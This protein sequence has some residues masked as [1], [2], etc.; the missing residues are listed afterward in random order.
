MT[1]Q[2]FILPHAK[3]N[4]LAFIERLPTQ[5]KWRVTIKRYAKP[6]SNEQNRYLW[7]VP[8]KILA[9][10]TGQPAEDWHEYML[11]ECF[12]WEEAEMFGRK[13]LRP[14]R[15]SSKLTTTEFSEFVAFIQQRAAEHGLY[16]PDP[17][18]EQEA[19]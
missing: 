15:R 18:E 4:L 17:N 6:R 14:M 10:A 19:A 8:Y 13:K 16:I 3:A 7:G 5:V 1:E 11:G 2:T 9:D 12:G